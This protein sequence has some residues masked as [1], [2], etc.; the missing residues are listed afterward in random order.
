MSENIDALFIPFYSNMDRWHNDSEQDFLP[1]SLARTR[2]LLSA[3]SDEQWMKDEVDLV[4][5]GKLYDFSRFLSWTRYGTTAEY[6]RY[7]P[8]TLTLLSGTY[9]LNLLHRQGFKVR[10]ANA[11]HRERLTELGRIYNPRFVLLSTTLLFD[12]SEKDSVPL[13]VEQLRRQWPE[14]VIVLGGLMLVSYE[15]NVPR[16]AFLNTLRAY[17]ADAYVVSPQGETAIMEILRRGSREALLADPDIPCTYVL[18]GA[19]VHVPPVRP[20]VGLNMEDSH[21]RWSSLPQTDH[22]YHTVHMRTARSCAFKCAFCEYPVN[23]GPLTLMP[24]EVVDKEL[25]ELKSLGTVRSLIFTDDT[26]NVPLPRFKELLKVLAKYDFEW[27]SFFRPQYADEE[28]AKL[29]KDA[30][31][32]AVFAGLESVDDQVLK[33]MNKVAKADNYKRGIEQLKKHDIQVHANFIVGFPGETE[34]SA[35]KIV[36]F[37]DEMEIPFCTVCTWVFIPST[38]IGARAREFGIKG[39]GVEWKHDTMTS[40]HAQRLAR[41]V[42]EEQKYSI[43]NAVRG[44]A[45]SEFLLYAN[46]FNVEEARLAVQTFNHYIGRDVAE[47]EIRGSASYSALQAV[48]ERH[49]MPRPRS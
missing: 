45:W 35:F 29:M 4:I 40:Q 6:E 11:V 43:H 48:L 39:M 26:F 20:E 2:G 5:D 22:L 27:Y 15:K 32:K 37:L 38:P 19:T 25:Q 14:A 23:Q 34:D 1:P 17:N 47:E 41:Q 3:L 30:H 28:T 31:C 13:A 8:F 18:S 12:A 16:E 46:G 9:Y 42:V 24:V 21:I 49:T 36:R 33:N 7:D 10:V 44:E